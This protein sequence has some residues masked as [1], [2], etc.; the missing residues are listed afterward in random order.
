MVVTIYYM[1]KIFLVNKKEY[2]SRV[3]VFSKFSYCAHNLGLNLICRVEHS[4]RFTFL[5]K[6]TCFCF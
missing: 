2:I 5:G 3:C 6:S 4:L 1:K